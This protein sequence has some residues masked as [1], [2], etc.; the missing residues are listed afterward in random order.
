MGSPWILVSLLN[1]QQDYQAAL[2]DAAQTASGQLGIP[3]RVVFTGDDPL[4]QVKA[5]EAVATSKQEERP[6]AV[7]IHAA[8]SFGFERVARATLEA[9]IGWVVLSGNAPYLQSLRTSFPRALISAVINDGD[10]IGRMLA[11]LATSLLPAG[12]AALPIEGPSQ[13]SA[14]M[15]RRQGLEDAL[16]GGRITLGRAVTADWTIAGARKAV[17]LALRL[18]G[19]RSQ[20]PDLVIAQ[21]DEMA[22]GA[23]EAIQE[24]H[25]EWKAVPAIGVDGLTEKGQRW[26]NERKLAA[27]VVTTITG[28]PAIE[29]VDR[30]LRGEEVPPLVSLP[31]RTHPTLVT[32]GA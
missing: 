24:I 15:H 31:L 22:M 2:G 25:P 11:Q 19:A 8:G 13:L 32:P 23:V 4:A 6:A 7:V 26:V 21:N 27:S 20:R 14:T 9:G 17:A 28:G 29:L 12:G 10:Q 30:F 5:I 1:S 16:R 3:V 18:G